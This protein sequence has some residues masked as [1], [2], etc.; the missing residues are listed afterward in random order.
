MW[1]WK[2]D[3]WMDFP[4]IDGSSTGR[5][6]GYCWLINCE[7]NSVWRTCSLTNWLKM[8]LI[9]NFWWRVGVVSCFF[10]NKLLLLCD[11]EFGIKGLLSMF[12][13]FTSFLSLWRKNAFFFH[14][15]MV[16]IPLCSR[17]LLKNFLSLWEC[18][19]S[20]PWYFI[21]TQVFFVTVWASKVHHCPCYNLVTNFV[22]D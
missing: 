8:R 19:N 10:C 15:N 5:W 21:Q 16:E 20:S 14:G 11:T 3:I 2:L 18:F 1:L 22:Q 17:A 4:R 6:N 9:L 12:I 13:S 7:F